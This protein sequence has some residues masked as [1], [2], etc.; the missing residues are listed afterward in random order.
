MVLEKFLQDIGL[1]DKE[2]KIYLELIKVDTES[3]LDL[4]R[5]T[6]INRTSIYPLLESLETKGLIGK[7]KEDKKIRYFAEP[8]E[9]LQTYLSDLEAKIGEQKQV[10]KD[11]I[12]QIKAVTKE[13][14]QTP[15]VR[16]YEGRKGILE[17]LDD[18]YEI[19]ETGGTAY[20]IYPLDVVDEL[21]SA[22]E[23]KETR[24]ARKS[25]DIKSKSIYSSSKKER[26]SD[27][28]AERIHVDDKEFPIKADIGIYRDKVRFAT[29]GDKL[30]AIYIKNKDI[31]D[32]LRILFET[33]FAHLKEKNKSKK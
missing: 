4:S 12:P 16:Y 7:R 25:R 6:K 15:V 29:L 2:A 17:S 14:G 20:Y 24:A 13:A 9:R 31:A 26:K 32:T 11:A 8:P 23:L 30:S 5:K 21:F 27:P 3:V 1:S 33:A 28:T 22:K 19:G 10:L 18:I